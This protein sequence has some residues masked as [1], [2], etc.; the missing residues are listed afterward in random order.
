MRVAQ[1]AASVTILSSIVCG[2]LKP[3]GRGGR[4][5]G[6]GEIRWNWI[7]GVEN[8]RAAGVLLVLQSEQR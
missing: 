1:I 5:A 2:K 6:E 8:S 7:S 4:A 3:S